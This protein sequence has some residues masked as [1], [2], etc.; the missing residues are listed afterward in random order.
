MGKPDKT[1]ADIYEKSVNLTPLQRERVRHIL[2]EFHDDLSQLR[3]ILKEY[4]DR[5]KV[6]YYGFSVTKNNDD[7][8]E[9]KL[10]FAGTNYWIKIKKGDPLEEPEQLP[11]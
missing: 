4:F 2:K 9:V 3:I 10:G 5:V 8:F 7:I 11:D 1:A 6:K